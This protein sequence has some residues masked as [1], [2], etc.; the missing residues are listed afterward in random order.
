[1]FS[2]AKVENNID[3]CFHVISSKP[4][5]LKIKVACSVKPGQLCVNVSMSQEFSK[6]WGW[7]ITYM[8]DLKCQSTVIS[9]IISF[10]VI[11]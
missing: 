2:H 11:K 1:M 7:G 5:N 9:H 6:D 3:K 4:C 10:R 8:M